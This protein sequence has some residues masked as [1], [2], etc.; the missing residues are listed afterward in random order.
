MILVVGGRRGEGGEGGGGR[1][2]LLA[3]S[4]TS[5]LRTS[6]REEREVSLLHTPYPSQAGQDHQGQPPSPS[7][8]APPPLFNFN[9]NAMQK[10]AIA[11]AGVVLAL[12]EVQAASPTS[13]SLL[14]SLPRL[15][16]VDVD[17]ISISGL[18]SG[19][20]FAS[21]FQLAFSKTVM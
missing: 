10:V 11:L 2:P 1:V 21:N 3:L 18:S 20:D 17:K 15:S 5:N 19:A 4:R 9:P 8:P 13:D 12:H 7:N 16:K 14:P 6:T